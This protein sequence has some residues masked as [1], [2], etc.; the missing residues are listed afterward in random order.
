M[1][2]ASGSLQLHVLAITDAF[3][4]LAATARK[5]LQRQAAL[6][7]G[8]DTNLEI[9]D[10]VEVYI[11]FLSAP[12]RKAIESGERPRTL[13][14]YVSVAKMKQVAEACVRTHGA[15]VS[16]LISTN[17]LRVFMLA[18]FTFIDELQADFTKAEEGVAKLKSG[19]DDVRQMANDNA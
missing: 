18:P 9:I 14:D 1:K 16:L 7:A 19:T 2:I 10:K 5:D 8:V 6:L 13:G 12:V 11:E 4:G 15:F 17:A 3:D